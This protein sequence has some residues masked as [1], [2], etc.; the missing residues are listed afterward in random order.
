[1]VPFLREIVSPCNDVDL[2]FE[3]KGLDSEALWLLAKTFENTSSS[4]VRLA[5]CV[6][7]SPL[8]AALA[9]VCFVLAAPYLLVRFSNR[10]L[11]P[12]C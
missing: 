3:G 9:S 4:G 8:V 7:A 10:E 12:L 6:S 5:F 2:R 1:M 11:L